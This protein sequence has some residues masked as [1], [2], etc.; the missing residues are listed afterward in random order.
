LPTFIVTVPFDPIP[1]HESIWF[2][3]TSGGPIG[4]VDRAGRGAD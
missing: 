4:H 2:G 1:I 3:S